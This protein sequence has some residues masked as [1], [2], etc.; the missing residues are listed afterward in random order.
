[1]LKRVPIVATVMSKR[2]VLAVL[3]L[4][5][6]WS[7]TASLTAAGLVLGVTLL[8]AG[9]TLLTGAHDAVGQR[10]RTSARLG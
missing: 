8:A 3:S 1:V 10:L 5:V 2:L 9:L 7:A 6:G 4:A